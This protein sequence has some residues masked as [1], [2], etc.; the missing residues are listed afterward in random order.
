MPTMI[1]KLLENN[2]KDIILKSIDFEVFYLS[3]I[4][5]TNKRSKNNNIVVICPFHDDTNPSLAIDLGTGN[6]YCFGC[7]QGGSIFDFYMKLHNCTFKEALHGL[8][9]LTGVP[10]HV[11]Q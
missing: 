7:N 5:C 6:F 2:L 1:A 11:L 10:D 8:G 3:V 9:N 4:N